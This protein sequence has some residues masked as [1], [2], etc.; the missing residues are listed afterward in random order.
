MDPKRSEGT[1]RAAEI[2]LELG[3]LEDAERLVASLLRDRPRLPDGYRLLARVR[4]ARGDEGGSLVALEKELANHPWNFVGRVRIAESHIET[5]RPDV[6]VRAL[7]ALDDLPRPELAPEYVLLRKQGMLLRS[8]A[9]RLLENWAEAEKASQAALRLDPN[10]EELRR[11]ARLVSLKS[12][13]LGDRTEPRP[14]A[15][16]RPVRRS[17]GP[18]IFQ[19]A[20]TVLRRLRQSRL[21]LNGGGKS[22]R[23]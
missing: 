5:G 4:R 11:E 15:V 16:P 7:A 2:H 3:D 23:G 12:G 14:A 1:F 8:R 13:E 6:A 9:H 20:S 18:N 19:Y 22:T 17:A 21:G 10:D